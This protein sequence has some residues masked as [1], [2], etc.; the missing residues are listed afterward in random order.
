MGMTGIQQDVVLGGRYRL[1]HR[2]ATGGMGTVWEA[3]DTLLHRRVAVKLLSEALSADPTFVERFRR[4]ARAAAGLSHPNVAGVFDYG[5]GA[6]QDGDE[7]DGAPFIGVPFIVMELI[8]G[9]TLA[10][11]LARNG[12]LDPAEAARIAADVARALQAAHDAAIVHRDV[13]PG[14]V[15]ITARGDVKVMDFGIAAAASEVPLT[16]TGV[17]LGTAAYLSPEQAS[18]GPVTPASD[19]Y[20]L[21]CVLY[22]LLTGRPPFD[23]RGPVAMAA[24]HARQEPTP[25]R[26]VAPN[27]PGWLAQ[28]CER[29]LAKDPGHRPATAAAFAAM[30]TPPEGSNGDGAGGGP[31]LAAPTAVLDA[32]TPTAVLDAPTATAVLGAPGPA[33]PVRPATTRIR[34]RSRWPAVLAVVAV[35]LA[36]GALAGLGAYLAVHTSSPST[37]RGAPP[38]PSSTRPPTVTVPTVVGLPLDEAVHR[39]DALGIE[40]GAVRAARGRRNEVIRVD[41]AQGSTLASGQSVTL[42]VGTGQTGGD[43]RGHG[44]G[45]RHDKG[46]GKD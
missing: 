37:R 43:A 40:V 34:R 25:V 20:S 1:L 24:A 32:P 42:Y 22:E 5:D 28:A 10:E 35:L 39:L 11:R 4:E 23:A 33:A 3:E 17:A 19:V 16:A 29:A 21:G 7:E 31:G 30:L 12:P 18:G 41:P 2:I 13:K 27:V 8:S 46:A 45:K 38:S 14:N 15:M 9:Q 6:R 26:R 44:H 36:L